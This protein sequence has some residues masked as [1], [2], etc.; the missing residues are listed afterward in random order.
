LAA[1][2]PLHDGENPRWLASFVVVFLAS[3]LMVH[4]R[5]PVFI[6]AVIQSSGQ[7]FVGTDR[8]TMSIMARRRVETW[9][10]GVT[11]TVKWG[12]VD[13]DDH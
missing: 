1:S 10:D 9:H 6:D 11:R 3:W 7:G 12:S 4:H 8:S 13:A 5:Y 2:G